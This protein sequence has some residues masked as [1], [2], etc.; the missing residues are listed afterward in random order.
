[1]P[2]WLSHNKQSLLL[3]LPH[4][5]LHN[6]QSLLLFLPHCLLHNKQSLVFFLLFCHTDFST[7]LTSEQR[8]GLQTMMHVNHLIKHRP[9]SGVYSILRQFRLAHVGVEY[10]DLVSHLVHRCEHGRQPSTSLWK[11]SVFRNEISGYVTQEAVNELRQA[12]HA[13]TCARLQSVITFVMCKQ[14]CP[15]MS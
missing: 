4:W 2:H 8:L 1:M 11:S 7:P 13:I 10:A 3:F 12:I 9:K 15:C 5:L 14:C 6:N